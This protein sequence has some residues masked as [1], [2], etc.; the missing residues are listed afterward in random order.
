M[1]ELPN[2]TLIAYDNSAR[3][4]KT[5]SALQYCASLIKFAEVVFVCQRQPS[6]GVN[7]ETI[8]FVPDTGYEAAMDFEVNKVGAHINTPFALFI[9]HDGYILNADA[10]NDDW[11]K[12]DFIGAPWPLNGNEDHP[13]CADFPNSRVGNTG[14][15]LKSKKFMS[16][17]QHLGGS[18]K[19]SMHGD[20]FCCQVIRPQLEQ[21]GVRFA[22][23]NVAAAFAWENNIEE[24][25]KGRPDAF[26]FHNFRGKTVPRFIV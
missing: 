6:N 10:W 7:G 17:C 1:K 13:G 16:Y 22:P 5:L 15:C 11:L 4:E 26:G 19:P 21:L 14:F 20:V 3:P 9:H 25:P 12:Y 23:I 24:Y 8:R 18:F 2:I